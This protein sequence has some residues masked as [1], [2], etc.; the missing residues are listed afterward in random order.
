MRALLEAV[1]IGAALYVAVRFIKK[2]KMAHRLELR[3]G[4]ARPTQRSL[5]KLTAGCTAKSGWP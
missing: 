1:I 3:V 2:K 4:V 5:R